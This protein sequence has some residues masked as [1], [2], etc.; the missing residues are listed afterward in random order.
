MK[1][2][3]IV[4]YTI[5]TDGV[6]SVVYRQ[7]CKVGRVKYDGPIIVV[8]KPNS[9]KYLKPIAYRRPVTWNQ[10]KP[11]TPCIVNK[12]SFMRAIKSSY[13]DSYKTINT[14]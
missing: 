6:K 3:D 11:D 1:L 12:I 13:W 9:S 10:L 7:W 5:N 8:P 2:M 4:Y 14:S